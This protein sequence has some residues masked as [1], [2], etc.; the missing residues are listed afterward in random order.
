MEIK[1]TSSADLGDI[2]NER[3][4]FSVLK[5]CQLKYFIVFKTKITDGGFINRSKNAYW[6][7]PQE[8]KVGDKIVLYTRTGQKSV[9]KNKDGSNTYFFFWGL[10]SALYNSPKDKIVL[11]NIKEYKTDRE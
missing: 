6:F 7:L 10:S 1:K 2:N 5:S 4:G 3:I 8:V 9:K 11:I